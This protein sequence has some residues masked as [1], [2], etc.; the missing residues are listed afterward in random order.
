MIFLIIYLIVWGAI[1]S[2]SKSASTESNGIKTN[3]PRNEP[4]TDH[5]ENKQ[6]G[7][8]KPTGSSEKINN[9]LKTS[10]TSTASLSQ[11]STTPHTAIGKFLVDTYLFELT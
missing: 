4:S 1:F 6:H 3:T 2:K 10:S 8:S 11:I 7:E 9:S 5:Y